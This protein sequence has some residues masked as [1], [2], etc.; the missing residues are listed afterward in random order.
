VATGD[1]CK[2][3]GHE[4]K[5]TKGFICRTCK[6]CK[7]EYGA[8]R[9]DREDL[10][11]EQDYKC[12][13]CNTELNHEVGSIKSKDT[14][15]IDHNHKVEEETGRVIIRGMLCLTCNTAMGAYD[16]LMDVIGAQQLIEYRK[17][18][19][20]IGNYTGPRLTKIKKLG[21]A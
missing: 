18:G 20:E 5:V 9:V 3:C 16:K 10:L 21:S 11:K 1:L 8:T 4:V 2:Y 6:D 19:I 12:K 17:G 7:S 15:C 13:L 14:A